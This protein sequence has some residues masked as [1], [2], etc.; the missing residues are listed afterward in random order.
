MCVAHDEPVPRAVHL[1]RVK[2]LNHGDELGGLGWGLPLVEFASDASSHGP[3]VPSPR[4]LAIGKTPSEKLGIGSGVVVS[5]D[6]MGKG[7]C[8]RKWFCGYVGENG[9]PYKSRNNRWS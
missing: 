2:G 9:V 3:A 4:L 6:V 8:P 5:K 7:S 1:R